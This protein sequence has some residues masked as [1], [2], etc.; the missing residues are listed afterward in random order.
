MGFSAVILTLSSEISEAVGEVVTINMLPGTRVG[1]LVPAGS[2]LRLCGGRGRGQKWYRRREREGCPDFENAASVGAKIV[3]EGEFRARVRE[4]SS[5]VRAMETKPESERI[6]EASVMVSEGSGEERERRQRR[7]RE[8]MTSEAAI[9][10]D[11]EEGFGLQL[12][13]VN[14]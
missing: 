9:D 13:E 6:S 10:G 14:R 2:D 5:R 3:R 11:S 1:I 12:P 7:V 4:T 8:T